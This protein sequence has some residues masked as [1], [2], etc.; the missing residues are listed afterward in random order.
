VG[1]ADGGIPQGSP[2]GCGAGSIG[3]HF[4]HHIFLNRLPSAEKL[5][6]QHHHPLDYR[7]YRKQHM[8]LAGFHLPDTGNGGGPL[9]GRR[10]THAATRTRSTSSNESKTTPGLDRSGS[11]GQAIADRTQGPAGA[12]DHHPGHATAQP[13]PTAR[14]HLE[15]TPAAGS[16][17]N[18]GRHRRA[19]RARCHRQPDL[20]SGLPSKASCN[21]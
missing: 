11:P 8:F 18:W 20:G 14:Q 12:Q 3:R 2:T 1:Q 6:Y 19:H 13:S 9:K 10:D 15:A 7:I 5:I 4:P 21:V 16:T 17:A